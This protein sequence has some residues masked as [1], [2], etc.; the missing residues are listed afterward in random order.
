M[1]T[2]TP[3]RTLLIGATGCLGAAISDELLAN[4]ARVVLLARKPRRLEKLAIELEERH[5]GAEPLLYPLD[6]GGASP[7]DYEDMAIRIQA[8]LGGLDAVIFSSAAFQGL[9]V[10]ANTPP[11]EFL[12]NI[13]VG[14]SAPVLIIQALLP[15]L[16]QSKGQILVV[17]DNT[18]RCGQAYWGAYGIAQHGLRGVVSIFQ[19]ELE[20]SGIRVHGFEAPM[21]DGGVH[22][23][24]YMSDDPKRLTQPA[25]VAK[26]I[27]SLLKNTPQT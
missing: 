11:L 4:Q 7:A 8:H 21:L 14:L 20:N 23:R 25:V 12:A 5:E 9:R 27:V 6:M 18:E 19:Q 10:L 3:M 24:A 1:E 16:M 17:Q 22:R 13:H 26:K 15:L 2:N